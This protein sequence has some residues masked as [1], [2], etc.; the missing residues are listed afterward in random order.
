MIKATES[1]ITKL[2]PNQI[3]VFGS[4]TE[5]IH[6]SGAAHAARKNFKAI[7]SVPMGLQGQSYG[8]ITKHLPGGMRS[9]T[10]N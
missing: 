1:I 2:E 3:F 8:I 7:Y 10:L 9:V 4:N 5:G 6:G